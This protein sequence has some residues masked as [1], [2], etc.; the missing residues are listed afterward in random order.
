MLIKSSF[1]PSEVFDGFFQSDE[2]LKDKPITIFNDYIPT[3]EEININPYNFLILNEPNEL[4]GFHKWAINNHHAFDCIFTWSEEILNK[5]P[6]S[7][8]FPFGM[9]SMWETPE[10]YSN[11][12]I[13]NK[14]LKVFFVCGAKNQIEGHKFRHKIY[15]KKN[16]INIHHE[17]I[18]SCP[19]EEKNNNFYSSMFHVAV[20]NTKQPNLFTE[21]IIDS[22]LTKTIPIYRGCSNIGEFFD[23]NGII[24]FNEEDELIHIINSLTEKD[25]TDKL[26]SIE[27]NYQKAIEWSNYFG[28]LTDIIKNIIKLNNL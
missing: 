21:K 9:S 7:I 5:C 23:K 24:E 25:Y 8:L 19:I 4:F 3:Q 18:Y 11:I 14:Y 2:L 10:L 12:N 13:K 27:H 28:R 17:W 20:E 16:E 15:N 6:N 22:F 1:I 26:Q